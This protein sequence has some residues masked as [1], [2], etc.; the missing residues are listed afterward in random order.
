MPAALKG[1]R[2]LAE[3]GARVD[4]ISNQ[5]CVSHGLLTHAALKEMTRVMLRRIRGAG[6]DIHAVRYCEHRS[7]DR[8]ACKKP[9]TLLLRQAVKGTGV[10]RRDIFFVGDSDVDIE[11]GHRFGCRTILVLTGRLKKKDI[12]G[13]AVKPDFVKKDLLEAVRFILKGKK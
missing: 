4:V 7:A 9:K 2:L 6:G 12:P 8:C 1:L 13:L 5:G 10:R 3:A 11:A